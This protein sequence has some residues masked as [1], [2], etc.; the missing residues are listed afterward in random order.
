M[1]EP[2]IARIP[3]EL[4][5][6]VQHQIRREARER[7][8]AAI[9]LLPDEFRIALVLKDIV[10]F[11]VPEIAQMLDEEE[12]TIRSRVHRARLKL[13]AL[14]D[15]LIPRTETQAS[16]LA[17]SQQTCLDLL[18]A[19]QRALDQGVEFDQSIIC[20]RCR[21][22]FSTLDLTQDLCKELAENDLPE[23][24]RNRLHAMA[25]GLKDR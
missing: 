19:K 9:P 17:Y 11:T 2:R 22:V 3:D 18:D 5:S 20:E 12:G 24:L 14:V 16:P 25:S 23:D 8:E 10:G 4:E 15:G 7:I 13:R 6:V 21:S 1:G